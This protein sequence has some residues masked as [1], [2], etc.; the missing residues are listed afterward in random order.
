MASKPLPVIKP[1]E[2]IQVED[3][4]SVNELPAGE[5][6]AI[7]RVSGITF[8]GSWGE[9]ACPVSGTFDYRMGGKGWTIEA[10][11]WDAPYAADYARSCIPVAPGYAW[12]AETSSTNGEKPRRAITIRHANGNHCTYLVCK[13][14]QQPGTSGSPPE[15]R[16]SAVNGSVD[17]S[18]PIIIQGPPLQNGAHS[19]QPARRHDPALGT[20]L[21]RLCDPEVCACVQ[22]SW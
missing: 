13:L 7:F 1:N 19:P 9:G 10:P 6:T 21:G 20:G 3:G 15:V 8:A 4:R 11:K 5:A 14:K 22:G 16:L 18:F 12:P 17:D 2:D